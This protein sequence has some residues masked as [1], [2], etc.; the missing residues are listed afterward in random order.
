V[1]NFP[2]NEQYLI[3][4]TQTFFL[5]GKQVCNQRVFDVGKKVSLTPH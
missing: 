4:L 1:V 5:K 2:A 3:S